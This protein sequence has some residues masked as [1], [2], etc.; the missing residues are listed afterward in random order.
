MVLIVTQS[1]TASLASDL[2]LERLQPK[3]LDV[4]ELKSKGL[5]VGYQKASFAKDDI[6]IRLLGY[7]ESLLIPYETVEQYHDALSNGEAAAI[8]DEIPYIR[9]FLA[10]YCD[11]FMMVGPTYKSDGFGFVSSVP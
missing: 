2:T 10:K 8:F 4:E 6:L 5:H 3:Y 9:I 7:N 11:K 1:Y